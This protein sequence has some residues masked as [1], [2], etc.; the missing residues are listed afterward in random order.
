MSYVSGR[1]D[2]LERA[3]LPGGKCPECGPARSGLG[4]TRFIVGWD[5]GDTPPVPRL[6]PRCGEPRPVIRLMWDLLGDGMEE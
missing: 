4:V 6:C 2:R 5:D 3:L 1:L